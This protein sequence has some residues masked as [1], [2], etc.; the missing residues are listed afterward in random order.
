MNFN[1]EIF[2]TAKKSHEVPRA[3]FRLDVYSGRFFPVVYFD[4]QT[5]ESRHSIA[6][7]E[8]RGQVFNDFD[9]DG[10]N[11]DFELGLAEFAV[12]VQG[13]DFLGFPVNNIVTTDEHGN[14]AVELQP[15]TYTITQSN[16]PP[17][18]KK[19]FP[20]PEATTSR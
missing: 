16:V 14:Y 20:H 7:G 1:G 9:N 8:V 13:T 15:G 18:G 11:D 17:T 19:H 3:L 10:T 4:T 5:R 12:R 2:M 6:Q